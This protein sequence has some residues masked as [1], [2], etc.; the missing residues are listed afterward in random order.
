MLT[1]TFPEGGIPATVTTARAVHV[2]RDDDGEP[3]ARGFV[4]GR[5][6]WIEWRALGWFALEAGSRAARAWPAASLPRDVFIATFERVVQPVLLQ[7]IGWQ[8]LHASAVSVP[9][10]AIALCGRRGSGKSTIAFAMRAHG[11]TQI[12]DDAVVIS[13]GNE[14]VV[15]PIPFTPRLRETAFAH[16][17]G[18]ADVLPGWQPDTQPA[19]IPLRAAFVLRQS[20]DRAN[21]PRVEALS[22]V[23]AFRELLPHAHSFDETEPAATRELTD[24]YLTVVERV[25]IFMLTY[26]SGLDNLPGVRRAIEASVEAFEIGLTAA[27]PAP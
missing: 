6:R 10:G 13:I 19:S 7:G 4:E 3:F 20:D 26:R 17:A 25:P 5:T 12:A 1:L 8:T 21:P 27:V 11:W 18:L 9:A 16:F 22:R 14:V 2:W 23:Q 15:H 24:E